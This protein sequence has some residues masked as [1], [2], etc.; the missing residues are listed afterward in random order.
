MSLGQYPTVTVKDALARHQ[1]LRA[2]VQRGNDPWRTQRDA[3]EREQR[4]LSGEELAERYLRDW[5][6]F[7][8]APGV[9]RKRH[10][11][12]DELILKRDFVPVV[13]GNACN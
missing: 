3:I 11:S 7:E 1:E 5:A 9:P 8:I 4:T 10:A 2:E 13:G 6:Y 12:H